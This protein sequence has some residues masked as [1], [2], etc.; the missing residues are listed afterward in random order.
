MQSQGAEVSE[1][2][3]TFARQRR[4]VMSRAASILD[5]VVRPIPKAE[6]G[7]KMETSPQL[8][9]LLATSLEELVPTAILLTDLNGVVREAN[10]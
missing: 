7:T 2:I 9:A 10:H 8:S 6:A 1:F 4:V 3:S 5:P